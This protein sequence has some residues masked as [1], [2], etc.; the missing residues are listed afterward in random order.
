MIYYTADLHLRDQAI[1][2][3]CKRPFKNLKEMEKAIIANWNAKVRA[4]DT[5][6][7]LGDI[8]SEDPSGI[9][10]FRGLNGHKCLI[11]GNHDHAVLSAIKDSD[12]FESIG[13]IDVIEDGGHK[14]CLCHY[15][16]M[17]WM[18]FNRGGYLIYGHVHNKT[19]V[20]G[21]AYKQMKEYFSDKPAFNCG[22]DVNGFAPVT[23]EEM[24]RSKE[25]EKHD[26][27]IH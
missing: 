20:N 12:I 25:E 4:G 7:V 10:A 27:Y 15:P 26:P 3:K 5:V 9:E 21:R 1:F 14:V 11:V 16:L 8:I 23:L 13:F 24:I 18:E 19:E 2:D 6:Y 22:V 17:D